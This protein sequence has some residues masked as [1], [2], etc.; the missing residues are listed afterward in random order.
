[1]DKFVLVVDFEVKPGTA[2]DVIKYVSENARASV[3]NEPGCYQFDVLRVPDN[4]NRLMLYEVYENEAAFQSHGG[5]AH[6]KAFLEKSRPHFVKTT[7]TK[8]TR[9]FHAGK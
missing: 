3:A 4:P 2:D 6:I 5:T 8:L 9:K 1:M 7:M